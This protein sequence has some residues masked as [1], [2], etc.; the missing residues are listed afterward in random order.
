MIFE[1]PPTDSPVD[2]GDIIDGCPLHHLESFDRERLLAERELDSVVC[3]YSRVVVLTQTCD[4]ASEE[5]LRRVS[6]CRS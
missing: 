6:R 4:L 5:M 2:Q 1:V 3:T